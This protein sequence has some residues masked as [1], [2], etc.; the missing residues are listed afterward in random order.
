VTLLVTIVA[1]ILGTVYGLVA[2]AA[3][4][5]LGDLAMRTVDGLLGIPRLPLYLVL[6]TLIGPGCW[7]VVL[8]MAAFEWLAFARL[9]YL[10]ALGVQREPYVEAA[11]ALG[12]DG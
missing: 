4:S 12:A 10:G 9:A 1:P 5:A 6:L 3:P 2:A 11:R 7:S 8:I